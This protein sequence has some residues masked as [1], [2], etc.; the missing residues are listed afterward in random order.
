MILM[1]QHI[2]SHPASVVLQA[3][4]D[5]HLPVIEIVSDVV[6]PWCFIGKRRLEKALALLD[7]RDVTVRWKPFQLNPDAP[8]E[9]M[10]RQAH[11]A[12]KFGSLARA[13]ELEARV[14]AAGTEEDIRFQFDRIQ[15]IPNTFEAHRLIWF[16]GRQGV[17]D[18]VVDKLFRAYF[19]HA[20]DVGEIAVLKRIGAESGLDSGGLEELFTNKLGTAEVL[21]EEE[22]AR[23]KGVNSVP[24]FFVNAEPV[25]AGAH[26]SELL[27]AFLGQ[28]LQPV[29][30]QCSAQ[31]GICL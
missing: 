11:R 25:T 26:K 13:R 24:T 14:A 9:G 29:Q 5:V 4:P 3:A 21:A 22:W 2:E 23:A 28:V 16:A 31:Q 8:K 1:S 18:A 17:Q 20:E 6:C 12:R 19:N 7:R 15:K 30:S 10:D 27:A